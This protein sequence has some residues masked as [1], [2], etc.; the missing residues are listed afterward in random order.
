MG[1]LV[2]ILPPDVAT[3]LHW[4][5][6]ADG[7][8][9]ERG[10]GDD[11]PRLDGDMT[12]PAVLFAPAGAVTL[13]R[14]MLPDLAPRQ[15]QAAARLMAVENALGAPDELH[16]AAGPRDPEG[17]LD[18]AVVAKAD[19]AT[20][21]GWAAANALDAQAI[22][23]AALLLPRSDEGFVRGRVGAETIARDRSTAF[24]L[25]SGLAALLIDDVP[26]ADLSEPEL[27]ANLVAAVADPP[28]DLRQGAFARRQRRGIDWALVRRAAILTGSILL[29]ALAMALIRIA[30][31]DADSAR[32][33][34]QAVAN[35]RTMLPTVGDAAQAEAALDA[36][37]AAL[38]VA[39]RGFANGAA[40]VFGALEQAPGAVLTEYS[41]NNDGTVRAVIAAPTTGELDAAVAALRAGGAGTATTAA[42]GSDG[43]Q[44]ITVTVGAR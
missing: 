38:G 37:A 26:V 11:W 41:V 35:A 9:A 31:L 3:P 44:S 13:H 33:D 2:L 27:A 32:L 4:L 21:L 24:A 8:V 39:G 28:L 34:A 30:R 20:W 17:G 43:R 16:V 6:I 36:R 7:V 15:A 22:V 10:V 29:I 19:M 14:A 42:P 18:V 5:T 40:R 23:P 12:T 1:R 25:E